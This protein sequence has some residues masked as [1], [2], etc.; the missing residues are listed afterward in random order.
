MYFPSLESDNLD[1]D[2]YNDD[3]GDIATFGWIAFVVTPFLICILVIICKLRNY[4]FRDIPIAEE[5]IALQ[6]IDNI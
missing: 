1:D 2:R 5:A 4:Y 3:D 6:R